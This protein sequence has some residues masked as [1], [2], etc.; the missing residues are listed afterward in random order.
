MPN[1]IQ[2]AEAV[3]GKVETVVGKIAHGVVVVWH[4]AEAEIDADYNAVK[5]A[6]PASAQTTLAN[7]V[8][9]VKQGASDMLGK[10]AGGIEGWEPELASSVEAAL[11]TA[12][13]AATNGLGLPLVPAIN[14]SIGGMGKFAAD[15]ASA[16][17]LKKQAAL[18]ANPGKPAA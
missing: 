14:G 16:W 3:V 12:F 5:S 9:A 4:E 10:L 2:E 8:S 6:L 18:A 17:L 13:V 1:I 7:D 11:D 15:V